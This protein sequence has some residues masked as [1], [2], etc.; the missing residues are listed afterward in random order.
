MRA[1]L[2]HK[3]FLGLA[4][5]AMVVLVVQSADEWSALRIYS[6][7]RTGNRIIDSLDA[8]ER[9]HGAYPATLNEL[10]PQ[11]LSE[12]PPPMAGDSVWRY[13]REAGA[14]SFSLEFE[15]SHSRTCYYIHGIGWC[16]NDDF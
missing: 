4:L 10:V 11:Y 7:K 1:L 13:D 9:D 16:R 14:K 6:S 12:L 5:L 8:Y 2:R 15:G 3:F